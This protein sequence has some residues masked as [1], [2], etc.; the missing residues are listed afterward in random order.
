MF[1]LLSPHLSGVD[2]DS[3]AVADQSPNLFDLSVSDCD[4]ALRPI[5][6]QMRFA[7]V[8]LTIRETVDHDIAARSNA[9]PFRLGAIR[10]VRVRHSQ[11]SVKSAGCVASTDA[12]DA[13]RSLPVALFSLGT[14]WVS[15]ES[16]AVGPYHVARVHQ[17]KFSFRLVYNH[18]VHS[19]FTVSVLGRAYLVPLGCYK[20][21]DVGLYPPV[22]F[23]YEASP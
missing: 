17:K 10:G 1:E 9:Q 15:S 11:S 2:F 19:A 16:D 3:G 14:N 5:A 4:A 13:L 6:L 22:R 8:P 21:A 23:K 12:V 7:D 18:P 20:L